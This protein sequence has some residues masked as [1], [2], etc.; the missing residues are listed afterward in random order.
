MK[1]R[2]LAAC[3][4]LL[5]LAQPLRAE[6]P[7]GIAVFPFGVRGGAAAGLAE[8]LTGLFNLQIQEAAGVRL[9]DED[10]IRD[11]ARQAA[12]EQ[13]CGNESCQIDLARQVRADVLIR[14]E[15]LKIGEKYFLTAALVDLKTKSTSYTDKV[16]GPEGAL[17]SL[18]EELARRV[19][20][21]L[22]GR[23]QVS[24]AKNSVAAPAAPETPVTAKSLAATPAPAQPPASPPPSP[25]APSLEPPAW[26]VQAAKNMTEAERKKSAVDAYNQGVRLSNDSDQERRLYVKA[27]AFDPKLSSAY[28]N[29]GLLCYRTKDWQGAAQSLGKFLELEPKDPDAAKIQGYVDDAKEKLLVKPAFKP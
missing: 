6:E 19:A 3:G 18:A 15:L 2:H 22:P 17:P 5:F 12:L 1:I 7:L 11:L 28:L 14:G 16:Q 27:L 21:H 10:L 23:K 9:I 29:L 25:P 13:Q 4:L 8:A 20:G 26:V 24:V